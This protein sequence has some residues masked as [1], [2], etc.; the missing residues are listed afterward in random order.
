MHPSF[1]SPLAKEV[2]GWVERKLPLAE[3]EIN[4]DWESIPISFKKSIAIE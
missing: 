2:G 4:N 1:P 3:A